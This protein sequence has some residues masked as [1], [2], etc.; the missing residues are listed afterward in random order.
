MQRFFL[1]FSCVAAAGVT[2]SARAQWSSTSSSDVAGSDAGEPSTISPVAPSPYADPYAPGPRDPYAP[3]RP[4]SYGP[5]ATTSAS[6]STLCPEQPPAAA[7]DGW[8][9]GRLLGGHRFP[10]AVFVPSVLS[11]SYIGVRAGLEYHQVPG[12]AQLPALTLSG[13]KP[14]P[15]DLRTVNVAETIDFA[16]RLHDYVA[17]YGDAYGRA[18]LGANINTLLG[19]GADYTYGGDLGAILKFFSVGGFQIGAR[20]Q[21]GYY[22]GQSAGILALFQDLSAIASDAI[23]RVQQNPT[24]DINRALAQLNASFRNAT[25][26]LVTP[27]DGVAYG[28]WI[29]AALGLG[30]FVGIQGSGG[31]AVDTATYQPTRFDPQLGQPQTRRTEMHTVR[32]LFGLA[33]DVDVSPIGIPLAAMLEYRISP[34]HVTRTDG[35]IRSDESSLEQ[36]VALGVYYSG[37]SD[38][39]LGLTVYTLFGQPPALGANAQPSGEPQDLGAQFVF[40]YFW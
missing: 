10:I 34:V 20:A 23:S 7:S 36:L 22:T 24:L 1:F 9:S 19:T 30:P 13:T 3:G 16:L 5:P 14:Q 15:V 38:L 21:I 6:P 40:R 11:S 32:P 4:P 2:G 31:F 27:F 25:A 39:Q 12:F 17:I 29:N 33:L 26:D 18:R 28:A 35:A 8:G 37:R